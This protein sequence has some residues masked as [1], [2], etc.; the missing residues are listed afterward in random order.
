MWRHSVARR[1][2]RKFPV[3]WERARLRSAD[4]KSTRLNSR[5]PCNLVCRLLLEKKNNRSAADRAK[6]VNDPGRRLLL[7]PVV[8]LFA[9]E[10]LIHVLGPVS[11]GVEL[12]HQD[13]HVKKEGTI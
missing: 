1:Q 2:S 7:H 4:R 13:N 6:S 5:S 12:R 11:H 3:A 8:A 10:R 9:E